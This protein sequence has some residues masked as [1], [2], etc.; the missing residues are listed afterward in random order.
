L[1]LKSGAEIIFS[2]TI[3]RAITE[4]FQSF[5]WM[6]N[7]CFLLLA[8]VFRV[9]LKSPH[10]RKRIYRKYNINS[11]RPILIFKRIHASN[12]PWCHLIGNW[13]LSVCFQHQCYQMDSI[14]ESFPE[15]FGVQ[16]LTFLLNIQIENR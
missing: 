9:F 1:V 14:K 6:H 2:I 15:E 3:F 12:I 10:P 16:E 4:G 5:R 8:T 13:S 11:W 7:F